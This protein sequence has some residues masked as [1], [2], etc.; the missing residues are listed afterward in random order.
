MSDPAGALLTAIAA[1][2]RAVPELAAVAQAVEPDRV[3]PAAALP[4]LTVAEVASADWSTKT[5]PGREVL[6]RVVAHDRP[7]RL[8]RA[9][10]LLAAA[11]RALPDVAVPGWRLVSVV[12]LRGQAVGGAPGA[13]GSGARGSDGPAAAARALAEWRAR[14]LAVPD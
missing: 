1:R 4:A 12:R 5:E 14:L 11:E 7:D 9:R 10:A 6:I 3:R 2:L 8:D 13:A